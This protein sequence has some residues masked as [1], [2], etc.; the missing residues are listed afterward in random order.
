MDGGIVRGRDEQQAD[1]LFH[2]RASGDVYIRSVFHESG[3]QCTEGIAADIK[4]AAEVCFN[5]PGIAGNLR[6]E[7]ADLHPSRQVA[8]Q[9]E[10]ARKASVHEHELT[11]NTRNPVRLQFPLGQAGC[12]RSGRA[13]KGVCAMAET[14]VNR[15]SSS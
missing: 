8:K 5:R 3:V 12:G 15:Q 10:F 14:L 13:G 9:R 6:G 2:Q 11:G 1:G 7:T 4:V